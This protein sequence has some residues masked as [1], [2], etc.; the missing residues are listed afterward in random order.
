[1]TDKLHEDT[2]ALPAGGLSRRRA[3]V[4]SSAGVAALACALGGCATSSKVQGNTP[5][6]AADYQTH[7]SGLERCGVCKHFIPVSGC[8]VVAAPVQANGWCKFYT[9]FG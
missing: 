3:L 5:Q 8:E 2:D 7:P 1:M 6:A 4:Q 9:L